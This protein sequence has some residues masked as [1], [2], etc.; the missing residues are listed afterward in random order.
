VDDPGSVAVGDVSVGDDPEG[1]RLAP[2][3]VLALPLQVLE[4]REQGLVGLSHQLPTLAF[5][6]HLQRCRLRGLGI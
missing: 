4:V 6:D 3:P 5:T 2:A 1:A